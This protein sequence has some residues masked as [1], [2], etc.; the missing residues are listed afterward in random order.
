MKKRSHIAF[1]LFIT[2]SSINFTIAAEEKRYLLG[3][4]ISL[5]E[6]NRE[7]YLD[8]IEISIPSQNASAFTENG[9]NFKMELSNQVQGGEKATISIK[10]SGFSMLSPYKGEFFLPKNW[11]TE[12]I[13]IIVIPTIVGLNPMVYYEKN[14]ETPNNTSGGYW[15]QVIVTSSK[16]KADRFISLLQSKGLKARSEPIT[17]KKK[18]NYQV[19][20]GPFKTENEAK[21]IRG[22]L[23]NDPNLPND[24]FVP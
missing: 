20:T 22:Q 7:H 16:S 18:R 10:K 2:L 13:K 19:S 6:Q 8:K 21:K 1:M 14:T 24:V 3:Q 4:L 15:V 9:G 12:Y 17:L 23:I 11:K 5:D